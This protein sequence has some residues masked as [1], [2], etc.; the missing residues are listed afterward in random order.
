VEL[1]EDTQEAWSWVSWLC[2][3]S[4]QQYSKAERHWVYVDFQI[5]VILQYAI[6]SVLVIKVLCMA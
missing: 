6:D 5:S 3:Y 2:S 4:Q 1:Q